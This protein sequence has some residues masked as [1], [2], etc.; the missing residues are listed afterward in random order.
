MARQNGYVINYIS[1]VLSYYVFYSEVLMN[2]FVFI[3]GTKMKPI[4]D[5]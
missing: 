2:Y 1:N 3:V 4:L 5:Y